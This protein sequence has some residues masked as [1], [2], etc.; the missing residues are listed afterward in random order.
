MIVSLMRVR[1]L[2]SVT[3][4]PACYRACAS[5]PPT[6][7][8][9]L[10]CSAAP[11]TARTCRA[12]GHEHLITRIPAAE[13]PPGSAP[14]HCTAGSCAHPEPR[15]GPCPAAGISSAR[16]TRKIDIGPRLGARRSPAQVPAAI[17]WAERH[18]EISGQSGWPRWAVEPPSGF[19]PGDLHITSRSASVAACRV[20]ASSPV[21]PQLR[22]TLVMVMAWLPESCR[23]RRAPVL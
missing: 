5:A 7:T 17:N 3:V 19:E 21:L 15:T 4:R 13:P 6:L 20:A 11:R 8:R 16:R 12:R 18:E 14:A 23:E 22:T 10:R 2:T 1:W 9:L